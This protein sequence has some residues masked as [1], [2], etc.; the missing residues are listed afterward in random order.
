MPKRFSHRFKFL[1]ERFMVRGPHLCDELF[2]ASGAEVA[3]RA[4]ARYG[5]PEGDHTFQRLREEALARSE[6]A[7]GVFRA[8]RGLGAEQLHLNPPPASRW[9]LTGQDELVVLTRDE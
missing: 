8:S 3:F 4:L 1:V 5:L 7:L 9:R 2:T 6:T